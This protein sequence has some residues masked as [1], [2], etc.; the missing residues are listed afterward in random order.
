MVLRNDTITF[1]EGKQLSRNKVFSLLIKP[2]GSTCNLRCRYC[3]YLDKSQLYDGKEH[4]MD[5]KLLEETIRQ[6]IETNESD[7][8]NFCW[9]GGEPL[10]A[11]LNF[12]KKAIDFQQKYANGKQISNSLQTN[13][14]LVN[15]DWAKFFNDNQFLIGVSIDG[16][17]E[18][19]DAFRKDTRG[20]DSWESTVRGIEKLY[21]N[22]VEYNT[23]STINHYSENKGLE[24]YQFLKKCGSNYMQFL[25]VVEHINRRTR[26]IASPF[27]TESELAQWSVKPTAFGEFMCD[28]FDEWVKHDVG[29]IFVQLFDATLAKYIGAS[30]GIC[31]FDDTCG[32]NLIIEHNGDI[33]VCDHFVYQEF[34]LGN[35]KQNSMDEILNSK[36]RLDFKM[37]K[38]RN[39]S[40][41]CL[42]CKF[43]F[44]CTGE[45][46]KHRFQN[47]KNA[48]CE[49]YKMFYEHTEPYFKFMAS[50]LNASRAPSNIMKTNTF[51]Q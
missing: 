17:K 7:E 12:Y 38:R 42:D 26:R 36:A 44:A 30:P 50:E 16:P 32:D 8:I 13:G 24:I 39:L 33:Y 15:D 49:G 27:D 46:P 37:G 34:K 40:Q 23:L 18:I 19:H 3:Y 11:G 20:N 4:I 1:Y 43:Y 22:N 41:E 21:R 14:T 29:Q 2:V 35:L 51:N 47:G 5:D 45:C 25:P 48:L 6:Y 31:I 9:H 10:F 28:I